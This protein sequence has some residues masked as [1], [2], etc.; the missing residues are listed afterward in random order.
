[1]LK[2]IR[3]CRICEAHLPLEPNP[4]VRAGEHARL[5]IVGQAPGVKV[6]TTGIPWN[7]VSGDRLRGWLAMDRDTFYD[8]QRV[9][10]VPMGFCYPGR[11]RG[12]DLP[13][14]PECAPTWHPQI[15]PLLK[16]V[17]LILLIGQ[18]AQ[19]GYLG[20]LRRE[21]LTET[22]RNARDYLP[23]YLPLP[24][25]SPRNQM[26]LRRHPWFEAGI[27][28]LLRERV[29]A[30]LADEV[31]INASIHARTGLPPPASPP[32]RTGRPARRRT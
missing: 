16:E 10:I 26:W 11:G 13:P 20:T 21:N 23:R 32:A 17:R 1:M 19:T 7:D 24:H 8:E 28:P 4:V 15:M 30:A 6:H 25:P 9:A 2:R 22:V 3:A 27:L 31:A 29:A 18:Y 5:L 12:G 14:R